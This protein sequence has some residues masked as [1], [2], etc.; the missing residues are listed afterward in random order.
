V[1][2]AWSVCQSPRALGADKRLFLL[3]DARTQ[4]SLEALP[5]A[6][7]DVHCYVID[8]E[9]GR[10]RLGRARQLAEALQGQAL[11]VEELLS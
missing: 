9:R 10:V 1:Q 8:C 6:P 3:T 5:P 2:Q 7:P 11:H 4:E